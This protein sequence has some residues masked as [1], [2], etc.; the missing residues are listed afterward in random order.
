MDKSVNFVDNH[1]ELCKSP[2]FFLT[3]VLHV[4]CLSTDFYLETSRGWLSANDVTIMLLPTFFI[5]RR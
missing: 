2:S 4:E 3:L 5:R 1:P